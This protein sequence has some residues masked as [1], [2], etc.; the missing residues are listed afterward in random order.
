M[1]R[2]TPWLV[3]LALIVVA[4]GVAW[5]R[6]RQAAAGDATELVRR[7]W[8]EG[9]RVALQGRQTVMMPNRRGEPI[10]VDAEV[11][12]SGDGQVR[13]RYLTPPLEGVVIWESGDRTYRFSPRRKRLSVSTRRDLGN[14]AHAD[15]AQL[16]QNYTARIV[17]HE[18]VAD[19]DAVVVELR[20]KSQNDRWRVLSIDT[21]SSVV[22]ASVERK[23]ESDV[24]R[25][26]RFTQIRYLGPNENPPAAS[27]QPSAELVRKYGTA[28]PG[29]T[30]SKF[31]P[32]V[33]SNLLGFSVRLPKRLPHGY[34]FRGA[35]QTPCPCDDQHQAARLEYSD[36]LN[37]VTLIECGHS[38]HPE[39]SD[40]FRADSATDDRNKK[41]AEISA[42]ITRR[43]DG[44]LWHFLAVG[45]APRTELERMVQSAAE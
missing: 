44:V 7:A 34:T 16:L 5:Y 43:I 33:L 8:T 9:R 32:E 39:G 15:E 20:P 38:T 1:R 17:R 12:A 41:G 30:S 40:C 25:S 19:R 36:G 11:L 37:G 42:S 31:T 10:T 2:K 28:R 35:Y 14:D 24:L 27:F 45:D 29:D 18:Q 21:K 13:I 23:G 3:A 4:V 22:L 26:S 6:A